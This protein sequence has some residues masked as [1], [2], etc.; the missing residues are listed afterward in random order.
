MGYYLQL[1]ILVVGSMF[2]I[3]SNARVRPIEEQFVS[4]GKHDVV[5]QLAIATTGKW[6]DVEV[7]LMIKSMPRLR[8]SF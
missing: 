5:L 6:N 3:G 1:I 7:P 4:R 8:K 2:L